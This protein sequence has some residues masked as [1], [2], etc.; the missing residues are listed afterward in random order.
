MQREQK[1]TQAPNRRQQE[2]RNEDR[3]TRDTVIGK[4]FTA[5]MKRGVAQAK[6]TRAREELQQQKD[7]G[8][9]STIQRGFEGLFGRPTSKEEVLRQR[10]P[11]FA[12]EYEAVPGDEIDQSVQFFARRLPEDVADCLQIFRQ[13]KSEYQI[14]D[15]IVHMELKY[16]QAP[17]GETEKEIFVFWDTDNGEQSDPEPLSL[18]L[19]HA[20]NVAFEVK[21]GGY[22][23]TQVPDHARMS[24]HDEIGTKLTD[25]SAD[26]RFNAM[27]VA[28]RQAK[29]REEAAMEWREK[30]NQPKKGRE[31]AESPA[32]AF[33]S[34]PGD[35]EY[36]EEGV[37][38]A[39]PPSYAAPAATANPAFMNRQPQPMNMPVVHP[40]PA[41]FMMP[42]GMPMPRQGTMY[43][44]GSSA[45]MA[46]Y[47]TMAPMQLRPSHASMYSTSS[48]YGMPVPVR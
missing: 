3:E 13:A 28:A 42:H 41:G 47:P 48:A 44:Y 39:L 19:S 1:P 4:G 10:G 26:A 36:P 46:G 22:V 29:L 17:T 18:F 20:A 40:P 16:R 21:K 37:E 34:R 25:G 45:P 11:V 33:E 30:Q 38:Q 9:I 31:L 23:I 8:F 27:E 14:N 15:E 24:F 7:G 43:A 35:H 6:P 32:Q 5:A 12:N 2:N